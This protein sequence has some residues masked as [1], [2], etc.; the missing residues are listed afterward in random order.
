MPLT[1]VCRYRRA[2]DR[3]PDLPRWPTGHSVVPFVPEG[4]APLV[5]RMLD[6]GYRNGG[7]RVADLASWWSALS[8]DAE[9]DPSLVFLVGDRS[10]VPVAAAICW[11]SAYVKDIVVATAARRQGLGSNL[12]RHV[13]HQF[14]ARGAGAVDLKVDAANHAAISLYRSQGMACIETL[15]V[16]H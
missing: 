5:H 13:F 4:H 7:G 3:L 2:L 1:E 9:Y 8:T 12:L 16:E 15:H 14:R 11:S 10:G 6:E